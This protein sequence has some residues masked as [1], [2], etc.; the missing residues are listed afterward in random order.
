MK[1][2]ASRSPLI[3]IGGSWRSKSRSNS[4]IVRFKPASVGGN[5]KDG[6]DEC[7]CCRRNGGGQSA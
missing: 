4:P 2:K 3:G 1:S 7:L 5:E 6:S